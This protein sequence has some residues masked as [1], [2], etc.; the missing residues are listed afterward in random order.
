MGCARC[1][2]RTSCAALPRIA[3]A[4]CVRVSR[5]RPAG[6]CAET[7]DAGPGLLDFCP[8]KFSPRVCAE[9]CPPVKPGKG[10]GGKGWGGCL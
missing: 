6:L 10:R 3:S 9:L 5:S 2:I 1:P 8:R 7:L 4:R